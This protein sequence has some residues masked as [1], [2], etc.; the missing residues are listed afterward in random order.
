M[1]DYPDFVAED[2]DFN[3][4]AL[5]LNLVYRWEYRPGSTIYL[6]WTH[7]KGQYQERGGSENP[8]WDRDP[9]WDNG[10]DSG[11]P[12]RTEPGNTFMA[13]ISY[14]FSI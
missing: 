6:V 7:S 8:D 4:G 12:F 2:F 1:R 14:W 10:F 5:N 3:F 9:L 13:K 11:F